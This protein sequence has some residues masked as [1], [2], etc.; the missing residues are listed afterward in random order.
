MK[1][2]RICTLSNDIVQYAEM[3]ESFRVAGF[4]DARCEFVL[5]DNSAG[6]RYEPYSAFNEIKANAAEPYVIFCHQDVRLN[7]GHG[8]DRLV[9]V[10]DELYARDPKWAVA[11]NAG[12][13]RKLQH[14]VRI[15]DP[16]PSANWQGPLPQPVVT[17]DEN[18][19]VVRTDAPVAWSSALSGFHFYGSD[20]CLHALAQKLGVYVIDFHLEHLST[21]VL[22]D[23]FRDVQRRFAACWENCFHLAFVL[24]PTGVPVLLT[25]HRWLRKL[26]QKPAVQRRILRPRV[27][28]LAGLCGLAPR[29]FHLNL[30]R[31][32]ETAIAYVGKTPMGR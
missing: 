25:K 23:A 4:D 2:F 8:F 7:Q 10:L 20:I 16:W 12:T 17:L 28:K 21:G 19:L 3:R 13:N 32:G 15:T 31:A 11:G 14:V 22:S 6:N 30:L 1:T 18:F 27:Q 5:L 29:S 9:K 24:T 26:V